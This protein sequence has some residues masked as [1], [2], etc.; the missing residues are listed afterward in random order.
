[1]KSCPYEEFRLTLAKMGIGKAR[2]TYDYDPEFYSHNQLV[3]IYMKR[4]NEFK[5]CE[6]YRIPEEGEIDGI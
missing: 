4:M 5:F 2:L 6:K 3:P 1:M